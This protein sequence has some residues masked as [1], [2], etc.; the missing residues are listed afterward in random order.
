MAP[1]LSFLA[2]AVLLCARTSLALDP[3][4]DVSQYAH[5]AWRVRDGFTTGGIFAIAQTRDG[6]LWLGT[7]SGLRRFDGVRAVR[8]Q[9]PARQELPS[10]FINRLLVG[11]D[12]RLWIGTQKGLASL[13]DGNL[14]RYP[15]L[16]G[17]SIRA[18]AE[19]GEGTVWVGAF[20]ISGGDNLCAAREGDIHCYGTGI[21]GQVVGA[22][23]EDHKGGLW[24]GAE[25]GLWRWKPGPPE[26]YPS[27]GPRVGGAVD[28]LIEDD[29]GTILLGTGKGLGKLVGREIESYGLF[30]IKLQ[31]EST[32][33][34]RSSDGSLWVG[35]YRGLVHVHEGKAEVFRAADGLTADF[36]GAVFEDRE[37]SVWVGTQDGLDRFRDVAAPTI[38][39][40][41]G[42]SNTAAWS[43]QATPDGSIW[44]GTADGLN[45]WASGRMTVYRS[46]SA[47]G[48]SR[49]GNRWTSVKANEIADNG[50][51]GRPQ[52]LGHDQRGRLW[53]STSEGIF[54]LE[55]ERFIRVPGVPGGV[56]AFIVGDGQGD[57]WISNSEAGL[58][59]LTPGLTL[60]R[61][62]WSQFGHRFSQG[63]LP[64]RRHGLWVGFADG[65]I[66]YFK[67][68]KVDASYTVADGL[69]KGQVSGLRFG[70]GG[71]L[72]AATEGGLSW[73]KDGHIGTLTS[74][75]GLPCDAVHW[76]MEDDDHSV[77]LNMPCGLVRIAGS[78]IEAWTADPKHT[79]HGRIFDVSD[80][81]RTPEIVSGYMPAVAKSPD[82]RI[83]FLP[84]DGVSFIDPHHLPFNKLPPPVHIEEVMADGKPYEPLNGMHLPPRLHYLSVNYTALS[85]VA[86]EKV[87]F[88]YKLEGVDPEWREVVNDRTVQYSNLGPRTYHFRV[89]ACNNSG[90]WNDEGATLEFAI[91]P[92]WYETSWFRVVCV[93]MCLAGVWGMHQLRVRQ[94]A[95]EFEVRLQERVSERNRVA[96]D[97]H[98]TLLQSF[99]GLLL[100]LQ[101]AIYKLPESAVDSR[102]TLEEAVE[103]AAEAITEARDAVQGL[104]RSTV[105]RNELEQTLR[106]VGEGMVHAGANQVS[107]RFGVVV[108][109]TSRDLH[110]IVRDEVYRLGAEALR[111]A[112]QHAAAQ[113]VE[114]EIR[115]DK[116]CFRLRVRDDG[117]G[118]PR[119]VLQAHGRQGHYGLPGMRERAE[120]V[121]G[122]LI[123]WTEV[124]EGTEIELIIAGAKAYIEPPRRFS[125]FGKRSATERTRS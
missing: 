106:I 80:G 35:T 118:I 17:P 99:H 29:R 4:L 43:V 37:G 114:V 68:G 57:V 16:T 103:H 51:S 10:N 13:K 72:W 86:P 12:G 52:A 77:W 95:Y 42:L 27:R 113:N 30:D 49:D 79:V 40:N 89:K 55:H 121:G 101:T 85:L 111:N 44:I 11:R 120:L 9:P 117:R 56:T 20:G 46:L 64:D 28:S 98:D 92:M 62:P 123:V 93:T 60:H 67:D 41:E 112:F 59:C 2:Y 69:G 87:R 75:N 63:L 78:D 105:E 104:R 47:V 71:D 3:S 70:A 48:Q 54:Y 18:L 122:K 107:P 53:A 65:G 125:Y 25:T 110:P 108:E 96:R 22:L 24:V 84:R 50:L 102:K 34:L 83:W 124:D 39:R 6:Y 15:E 38:S 32:R 61:I 14:S 73:L 45:R 26:H 81:V 100:R 109:G 97:L 91:D 76:S 21:L 36:V 82:G 5:T 90:V 88:R 116:K 31:S 1:K 23:Y 33:M 7:E 74:K 66:A 19:D 8:W 94:L 58:F 119:E 115:Y